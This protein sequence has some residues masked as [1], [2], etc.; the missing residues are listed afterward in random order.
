MIKK[1]FVCPFLYFVFIFS[2]ICLLLH[3]TIN[4]TGCSMD[5]RYHS[6]FEM[7]LFSQFFLY[8]SKKSWRNIM[9]LETVKL[10][11]DDEVQNH[12]DLFKINIKKTNSKHFG[13]LVDGVAIHWHFLISDEKINNLVDI[14]HVRLVKRHFLEHF[15][16]SRDSVHKDYIT[17]KFCCS[18]NEYF[19]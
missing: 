19:F 13:T 4:N 16:L 6:L 10:F 15:F 17:L 8:I 18:W 3:H 11:E 7:S 9:I 1:N 5:H 12:K 2:C 14:Y